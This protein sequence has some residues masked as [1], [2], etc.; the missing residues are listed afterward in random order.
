M[1]PSNSFS[2]E[3]MIL[4]PILSEELYR[5]ELEKGNKSNNLKFFNLMSIDL[6]LTSSCSSCIIDQRQE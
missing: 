4:E 2:R 3:T 5:L 6:M 1:D